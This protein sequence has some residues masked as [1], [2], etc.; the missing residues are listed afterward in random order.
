MSAKTLSGGRGVRKREICFRFAQ[1]R[2]CP[3]G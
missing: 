2:R 1:K 3:N